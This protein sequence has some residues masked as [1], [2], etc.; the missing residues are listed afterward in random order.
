[1]STDTIDWQ[2]VKFRASSWGSLLAE[3]KTKGELVGKTI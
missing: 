1:M 2:S 3:S